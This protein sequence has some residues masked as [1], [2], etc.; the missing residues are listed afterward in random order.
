MAIVGSVVICVDMET[1]CC[2]CAALQFAIDQSDT[3]GALKAREAL[4][5]L[6]R[7]HANSLAVEA[8]FVTPALLRRQI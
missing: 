3:L 8:Q 5:D 7:A 4:E 1:Y 2:A 6:R